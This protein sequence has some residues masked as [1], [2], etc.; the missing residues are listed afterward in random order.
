MTTVACRPELLATRALVLQ[1]AVVANLQGV[2][3]HGA[4]WTKRLRAHAGSHK[5]SPE[6]RRQVALF[7]TCV[8]R[9]KCGNSQHH[10]L[11]GVFGVFPKLEG[12]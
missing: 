7:A 12:A 9:R 10:S 5:N 6:A 2:R 1:L 8:V 3:A 11:N 4:T